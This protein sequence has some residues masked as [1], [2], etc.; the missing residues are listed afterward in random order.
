MPKKV[1]TAPKMTKEQEVIAWND[2]YKT[3]FLPE[4]QLWKFTPEFSHLLDIEVQN[5]V[6]ESEDYILIRDV[7]KALHSRNIMML[8]RALQGDRSKLFYQFKDQ[9]LKLVQATDK[10]G[11]RLGRLEFKHK[12]DETKCRVIELIMEKEVSLVTL[13]CIK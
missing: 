1:N 7:F 2:K 12:P 8:L 11:N 10:E 5:E 6:R 4:C 9:L 13:V 3:G